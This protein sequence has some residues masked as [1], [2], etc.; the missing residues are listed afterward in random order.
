[1]AWLDDRIWCHSKITDLSDRAFRTYI[2]GVAYS[3]GF[4]TRGVLTVGQQKQIRATP[5]AKKELIFS[6]LW[7][8]LDDGA[9]RIHDWDNHNGKRDERRD[10]DRERKRSARAKEREERP[11]DTLRT[12]LRT[13]RRTDDE[14][15]AGQDADNAAD[16]RALKEVKEVKSEVLPDT[17]AAE[18]Q[19]EPSPS[20]NSQ[21]AN[22]NSQE[23]AAVEEPAREQA[24][25]A[26]C[27]RFGAD[28]NIAEPYARQLTTSELQTIVTNMEM[29]IRRGGI[30][31]V[32]GQFVDLLQRH[33]K[34]KHRAASQ[35]AIH[36]PSLEEDLIH[37]A[38]GYAIGRHPWEVA[39]D[40]LGKKM[41]RLGVATPEQRRLIDELRT[42][43][44]TAA[45]A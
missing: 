21:H 30:V 37:D 19:K 9:V 25:L 10:A 22:G 1:M 41:N 13:V 45:A 35:T 5:R 6:Q 17:T 38:V 4:T 42:A 14:A 16:R 44:E 43:Y 31:S 12:N 18:I 26:A 23:P 39:E 29:K 36:V 27:K 20:L 24:I 3:S 7:D 11:Q 8:E 33:A 40:L 28:P 15:S 2:N 34:A 32:P